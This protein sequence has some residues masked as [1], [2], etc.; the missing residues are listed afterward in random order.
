MKLNTQSAPTAGLT[1]V[2]VLVALVVLAVGVFA[3]V[4]L[5]GTSLTANRTARLVQE[6]NAAARSELDVWKAS[7]PPG[8]DI[9]TRSCTLHAHGSINVDECT[10]R[11]KY[12]Q[13]DGVGRSLSC[14]AHK[15]AR[16]DA[17]L[18][19]VDVSKNGRNLT[20]SNV[21]VVP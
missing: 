7:A 4:G 6:L 3:M 19:E 8:A 13:A 11:F 16:T 15:P 12:C 2:E 21:M 5:Q 9:Q 1:L 14:T 17:Y 10:V 18:V 20:V